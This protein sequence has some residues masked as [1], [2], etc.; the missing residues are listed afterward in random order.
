MNNFY[1]NSERACENSKLEKNSG[2]H[3]F[4][5]RVQQI[6]ESGIEWSQRKDVESSSDWN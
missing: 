4:G 5:D 2:H 6:R 1:K 3:R